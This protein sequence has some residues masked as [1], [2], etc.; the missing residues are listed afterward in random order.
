MSDLGL[1]DWLLIGLGLI[2]VL[3][4][5]IVFLLI[6]MLAGGR[7]VGGVMGDAVPSRRVCRTG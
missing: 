7:K 6:A 3:L 4:V 5:V 1:W 2:V